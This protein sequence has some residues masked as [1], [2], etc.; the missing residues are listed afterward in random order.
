[1]AED[2][3]VMSQSEVEA[4]LAAISAEETETP[5]IAV[6]RPIPGR[7]KEKHQIQEFDFRNPSFLTPGE[8]RRLRIK[9]EEFIHSLAANLS[10]VLRSEFN[11]QMSRLETMPYR[12]IVA[13][14]EQVQT[15]V[16]LF[17]LKPLPQICLL[18]LS[19][20]LGLTVVDRMAGGPGHSIKVEREF[21]EVERIILENFITLVIREYAESWL[22]YK[23][24]DVEIV[25]HENT[26]RF[27]KIVEP[28]A[29]ML[30]LEMEARFGD[31][32]SGLRLIIPYIVLDEMIEKMIAEISME[33]KAL[34]ISAAKLPDRD[35]NFF[36]IPVPL[37]AH[38]RGF[39]VSLRELRDLSVGDIMML[40]PKHCKEAYVDL[41]HIPKFKGAI[42]RS[43][44][45]VNVKLMEK[46]K[47]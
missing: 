4:I 15:H 9:H 43:S 7:E 5:V 47:S 18:D 36:E 6:K 45:Y 8:M 35:S 46:L 14:N 11:L 2:G 29:L 19:P 40:D 10:I 22:K 3:Q 28:D 39:S 42:D 21:T 33:K 26:V 41:G 25:E 12:S 31:I 1:M 32:V 17:R 13:A 27:L 34:S 23:R 44:S 38:L 20:R 24:F 30:L 37:S 16:T